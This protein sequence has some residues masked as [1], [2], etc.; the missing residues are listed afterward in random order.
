[1]HCLCIEKTFDIVYLV[2]DITT[3][4]SKNESEEINLILPKE[5]SFLSF[6]F[7][8]IFRQNVLLLWSFYFVPETWSSWW[9]QKFGVYKLEKLFVKVNLT[10]LCRIWM[11]NSFIYTSK[12]FWNVFLTSAKHKFEH[13]VNILSEHA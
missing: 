13:L 6:L 11:S 2:R 8:K 5:K 12:N 10:K 1:M 3:V 7:E 4:G 9:K